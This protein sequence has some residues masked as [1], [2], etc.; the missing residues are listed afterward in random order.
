MKTIR[1]IFRTVI[2]LATPFLL[3]NCHRGDDGVSP[4]SYLSAAPPARNPL[5]NWILENYVK[6]YNIDVTYK[7]AES[8]TE[9]ERFLYPPILDS[10]QPALNIVTKLWI[11]PY[12]SMDPYLVKRVAPRQLVLVGGRNVDPSGTFTLGLAEG[13]KRISLFE[14]DLLAKNNRSNIARFIHTIQH[15]YVHILNQ[16]KPFD[17]KNYG[18]ITP[19]GY[20]GQWF[21][22]PANETYL[23]DGFITAYARSN[24]REDFAEMASTMLDMSRDEWNKFL[25]DLGDPG[26]ALIKQKEQ[27][28]VEYYKSQYNLD[29]YKLQEQVNQA[30]VKLLKK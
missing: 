10:V 28:V 12:S 3:L 1:N 15:E 13:G 20:T 7:W 19:S 6:P 5:D 16:T 4:G 17:E 11:E 24:E 8:L 25:K 9:G 26:A 21:N 18:Q 27:L 2:A 23:R 30:L 14:I 22:R 29:F